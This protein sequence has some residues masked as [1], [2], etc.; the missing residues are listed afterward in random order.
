MNYYIEKKKKLI[1]FVMITC[2]FVNWDDRI[3]ELMN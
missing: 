1:S 3:Y 2:L